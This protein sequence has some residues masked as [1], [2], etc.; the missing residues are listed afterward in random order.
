MYMYVNASVTVKMD[1]TIAGDEEE[2]NQ[3]AD[4]LFHWLVMHLTAI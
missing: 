4:N 3:I 2:G 1:E